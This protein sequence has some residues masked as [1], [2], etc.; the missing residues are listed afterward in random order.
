MASSGPSP[1]GLCG[2]DSLRVARH[3]DPPV[4]ARGPKRRVSRRGCVSAAIWPRR[5]PKRTR[6]APRWVVAAA[7]G[8]IWPFPRRF[9]PPSEATTTR[10]AAWSRATGPRSS[11]WA[12]TAANRGRMPIGIAGRRALAPRAWRRAPCTPT[13]AIGTRFCPR[14]ASADSKSPFLVDPALR[15]VQVEAVRN[16]QGSPRRN[17]VVIAILGVQMRRRHASWRPKRRSSPAR[18]GELRIVAAISGPRCGRA[19][20]GRSRSRRR[21]R[22]P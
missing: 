17:V 11:F 13:G 10:F 2:S 6:F 5:Q 19:R 7:R 9:W 20:R 14:R 8:R 12:V 21:R 4:R 1:G 18:T 3:R 15:A 16:C 22:G